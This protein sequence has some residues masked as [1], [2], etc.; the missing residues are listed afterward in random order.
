MCVYLHR[1]NVRAIGETSPKGRN[2]Y[3]EQCGLACQEKS[4]FL[5][6]GGV[7]QST[8]LQGGCLKVGLCVPP[9]WSQRASVTPDSFG[10]SSS[11]YSKRTIPALGEPIH[12]SNVGATWTTPC[13]RGDPGSVGTKLVGADIS[14]TPS[15]NVCPF[16]RQLGG[17]FLVW[18][19]LCQGGVEQFVREPLMSTY[20]KHHP[21]AT[22]HG[23]FNALVRVRF[24]LS[25]IPI[26]VPQV[27]KVQKLFWRPEEFF[28]NRVRNSNSRRSGTICEIGGK[29]VVF[30]RLADRPRL[31]FLAASR[32]A[33]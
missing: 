12:A 32:Y 24:C 1:Q 25:R 16:R 28:T 11:V 6:F 31:L 5:V 2:L 18:Q 19:P 3:D 15:R 23:P 4:H 22:T 9:S 14:A 33:A 26:V 30:E 10:E 27:G 13:L 8:D 20:R 29:A 7:L 21:R 17:P